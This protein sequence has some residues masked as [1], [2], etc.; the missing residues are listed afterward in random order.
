[1]KKEYVEKR[2]SECTGTQDEEVREYV[3]RRHRGI[4]KGKKYCCTVQ[5][6]PHLSV[7]VKKRKRKERVN[8]CTVS[9]EEVG[10]GERSTHREGYAIN[11]KR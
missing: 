9:Q 1:M 4:K 2:K 3:R 8:I 6:L 5:S 10:E 7:M 11:K